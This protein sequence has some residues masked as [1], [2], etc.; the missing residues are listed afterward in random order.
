MIFIPIFI[1]PSMGPLSWIAACGE[2]SDGFL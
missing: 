2:T 1:A